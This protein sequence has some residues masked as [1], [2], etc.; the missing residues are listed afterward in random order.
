MYIYIYIYIEAYDGYYYSG[1]QAIDKYLRFY[2]EYV[3]KSLT[4]NYDGDSELPPKITN[5]QQPATQLLLE[6][7]QYRELILLLRVQFLCLR[8]QL[9]VTHLATGVLKFT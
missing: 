9:W 5:I 2:T 4:W 1:L 8:T 6:I 7:V 3:I